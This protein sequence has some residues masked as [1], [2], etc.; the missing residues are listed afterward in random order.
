[1]VVA[2]LQLN[3]GVRHPYGDH[4]G[5]VFVIRFLS[6]ILLFGCRSIPVG[7]GSDC[8][9]PTEGVRGAI[10]LDTLV[11]LAG[12]YTLI[13][14][15]TSPGMDHWTTK[16]D[17][18]L[19]RSDTLQQFYEQ[20]LSGFVRTGNRPLVGQLAWHSPDGMVRT[21]PV[22]VQQN[23]AETQL[24]SGFCANCADAM[25]VY[26]RILL[27]RSNGF[28]GRWHDPQTGIGK[29]IDKNGKALPDPDGYFCAVRIS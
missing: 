14:V 1:M 5:V 3:L 21:D 6:L 18:T 8:T 27:I 19:E 22:V 25:F 13:T 4:P 15:A 29:L 2:C 20:R 7:N 11:G 16:S 26:H 28:S 24:I 17:L 9:P 12:K 10:P 23:P